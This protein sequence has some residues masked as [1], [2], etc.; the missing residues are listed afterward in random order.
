[1][2]HAMLSFVLICTSVLSAAPSA[3]ATEDMAVQATEL[4]ARS[5]AL[6]TKCNFLK[7]SD[8]R[9][10]ANLVSRAEQALSRKTNATSAQAV[11]N[12]GRRSGAVTACSTAEGADI[13][14]ILLA[15]HTAVTH[16]ASNA[17]RSKIKSYKRARPTPKIATTQTSLKPKSNAGLALY[18]SLTEHYYV[19]RRCNTMSP[20]SISTLYKTVVST[21][22]AVLSRFGR[23]AVADVM[24]HSQSLAKNES[25]R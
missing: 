3:L 10:L 1:M 5:Q 18:A 17:T 8:Q 23:A 21:H 12:R 22:Y 13:A 6:N 25:C 4:L 24:N 20:R 15:A 9:E 11:M 19:A 2:K 14:N 16:Q 7:K